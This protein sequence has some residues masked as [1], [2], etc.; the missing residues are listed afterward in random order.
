MVKLGNYFSHSKK[1]GRDGLPVMS[2]TIDNGLVERESLDRRMETSI[3][4]ENHL[5]VPKG[6]LAY[7]MMRMWQGAVG[8]ADE[9]CL[10]SPS[11]VVVQPDN[12]IDPAYARYLFK[13]DRFQYLLK[14]YSYG[15]TDDRWRLYFKDFAA[16]PFDAPALDEQRRIA[17]VLRTWDEAIDAV[18]RLIAAKQ[19]RLL[20]LGLSIFERHY[21]SHNQLRPGGELFKAITERNRPELPLLAVMQDVGI[22]RRDELERRVV[23]PE[24]KVTSYKVVMP[25]DFV[26][27]LRSFEGGL[28]YSEVEGLVSPAY[29]V[30]RPRVDLEDAYYKYL[31]KSASF[32]G[33]LD[34]IIFGIRDGKQIPFR[35]FSELMLPNPTFEE[36]RGAV[37]ILDVA[38]ADVDTTTRQLD[39]LKRQKRGLMQKLLTGEWRV[40]E[41]AAS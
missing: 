12:R 17:S 23:M 26:I 28:E 33:R 14:A 34:R 6:A 11:Y 18:S 19:R 27:S 38:R 15:V 30:V 21:A 8:F 22:V 1:K 20:Q 29:T 37:E 39:A 35:D 16:I 9:D 24:G 36:Q 5:L 7:N 10:V 4:P 31:F 2:V 3:D 25:G 13:S 41:G 40:P 32:V